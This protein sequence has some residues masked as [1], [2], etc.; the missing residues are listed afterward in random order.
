MTI[1]PL[2]AA[3]FAAF[4]LLDRPSKLVLYYRLWEQKVVIDFKQRGLTDKSTLVKLTVLGLVPCCYILYCLRS[5]FITD[6]WAFF[7]VVVQGFGTIAATVFRNA[8]LDAQLQGFNPA[9][10]HY[11]FGNGQE[12]DG[13]DP[14]KS[15]VAPLHSREKA[16]K[17]IEQV[18]FVKEKC[19]KY[20]AIALDCYCKKILLPKLKKAK[21]ENN[22]AP[23]PA[24]AAALAA[25][26]EEKQWL[27]E[28]AMWV[29]RLGNNNATVKARWKVDFINKHMFAEKFMNNSDLYDDALWHAKGSFKD[30]PN[31]T[32]PTLGAMGEV[33]IGLCIIGI[34]VY[35]L[36]KK[37]KSAAQPML[38]DSGTSG[39][40]SQWYI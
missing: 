18:Q 10:K 22:R 7:V 27:K 1:V 36:S 35:G 29:G 39:S 25:R 33:V 21:E 4:P 12:E 40:G 19:V 15:G 20:D 8:S 2:I 28:L 6:K 31:R 17:V 16:R 14:A 37:V 9:F 13:K 11:Q 32:G 24:T 34:E 5:D 23:T 26:E 3:M 30:R 38:E